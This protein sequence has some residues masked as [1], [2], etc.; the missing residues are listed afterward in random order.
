MSRRLHAVPSLRA[1]RPP[2]GARAFTL[3]ELLVVIAIIAVLASLLLPA[4]AKAKAKA[5]QTKCLNHQRQ[6][7]LCWLMYADDHEDALPPNE[8]DLGGGRAANNATARTWVRGNAF[9]DTNT[10]NLEQG[11]LFPY[12]RS[13]AIYKCPAD[14]STV[15]DQGR[16]PRVRSVAMSMYMNS[17]LDP[18]DVMHRQMWQKL[19]G[20]VRPGPAQAFV[21]IDEHEHSIENARFAAP[22]AADWTW[23][24]FPAVRHGDAFTLSF[25]DGHAEAWRLRSAQSRRIGRLPPWIQFQTVPRGDPDLARIHGAVKERE[26]LR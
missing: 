10:V 19:G 4:L 7:G 25:A 26:L 24:D 6:L 12:H 21:F 16:R 13:T 1:V 15:R 9:T 18:A 14:R 17:V 20:I 23:I 5:A 22:Q 8:T 11:V 2:R 3:I